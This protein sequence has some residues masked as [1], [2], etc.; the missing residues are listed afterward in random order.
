V[1]LVIWKLLLLLLLLLLS[2][3]LSVLAMLF[4]LL[5][6]HPLPLSVPTPLLLLLLPPLLLMAVAQL[7]L[8]GLTDQ[9]SPHLMLLSPLVTLLPCMTAACCCCCLCPLRPPRQGDQAADR[10]HCSCRTASPAG[11]Q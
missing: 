8:L 7:L 1:L 9:M 10:L 5:P 11:C 2:L 4:W 6:A 3:I